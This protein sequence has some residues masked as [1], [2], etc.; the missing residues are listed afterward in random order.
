MPRTPDWVCA[1]PG[2]SAR[3]FLLDQR[4]AAGAGGDPD[5]A[6]ARGQPFRAR[7]VSRA[8][9]EPA[10]GGLTGSSRLV[11]GWAQRAVIIRYAVPADQPPLHCY[12]S[13][14][15]QMLP[16]GRWRLLNQF[17]SRD[18][19]NGALNDAGLST[20]PFTGGRYAFGDGKFRGHGRSSGTPQAS[21]RRPPGPTM[22]AAVPGCQRRGQGAGIP[23]TLR[24]E[25]ISVRSGRL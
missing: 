15:Q 17:M 10:P 8:G 16:P 14:G 9:H 19:D 7:P 4:R 23:V 13:R 20:D 22:T 12:P 6:E 2:L 25:T 5:R 1:A 24:P 11:A 18:M 3:G 21:A